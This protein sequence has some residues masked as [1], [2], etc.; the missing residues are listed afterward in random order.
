MSIVDLSAVKL[1]LNMP[2]SDTSQD[3]ELQG[4]IDAAG[5]L[6]R[7]VIG[8]VFP[9]SHT[10]AFDGGTTTITVDWLPLASIVSV[11]EYYGLSSYALAEQPLGGQSNAFGYTVDYNTGQLTRRALG[12]DATK[13]ASGSKNIVIQY[14]AGR[15]GMVSPS[16]RLGALELI[17]HLWQLTQQ[18]G[19]P[20]FGGAGLDGEVSV[21]PTGFALPARVL[22]LWQPF[23][24]PPGIV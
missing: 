16:V 18:G 22:E 11:T 9:E 19:R 7:N 10:Q 24:R 15:L 13:F 21:V 12:G 4:F 1:H 17:R 2:V 20:Q 5:D 8:P 23:R 14:T 3:A 6:A